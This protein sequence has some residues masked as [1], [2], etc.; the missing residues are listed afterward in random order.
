[1][2]TQRVILAGIGEERLD[3]FL[4]LNAG[5]G[6]RVVGVID[7]DGDGE[8]ARIAEILGVQVYESVAPDRLPRAD[9]LIYG[10]ER[11]RA[12]GA[13]LDLDPS[14][15]WHENHAWTVLA[16]EERP[17]AEDGAAGED[18]TEDTHAG[19]GSWAATAPSRRPTADARGGDPSLGASTLRDP[20][21]RVRQEASA[22]PDREDADTITIDEHV[23]VGHDGVTTEDDITVSPEAA[24]G[25]RPSREDEIP[26]GEYV[27]ELD[28]A[29]ADDPGRGPTSAPSTARPGPI[30]ADR[31]GPASA[32]PTGPRPPRTGGG[33]DLL[34]TVLGR[35]QEPGDLH[36]WVLEQ[37]LGLTGAVAG[38]VV[39]TDPAQPAVW[40]DRRAGSDPRM[41]T[42]LRPGGTDAARTEVALGQNGDRGA[43]HLVL[44]RAQRTPEFEELLDALAPAFAFVAERDDL[45]RR[46][47]TD[48]LARE[49][50][51]SLADDAE[52]RDALADA[53]HRMAELLGAAECVVL[54]LTDHARLTGVTSTGEAM[55]VPADS[56]VFGGGEGPTR[57][58]D[59]AGRW[60]LHVP[61]GSD[62]R[63]GVL[64][65]H[66]VDPRA[67]AV[68]A[69]THEASGLARLLADRIP[70]SAWGGV[71]AS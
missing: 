22:G 38:S 46:A 49:L 28:T 30:P 59:E 63:R 31:S 34:R 25:S 55:S 50:S 70:A 35:L 68:E 7:E 39:P 21:D 65:V 15:V 23:T 33:Y 41:P 8:S 52:V 47:R 56:P 60:H 54:L 11:Y 58:L 29:S 1:M 16:S 5:T 12:L 32:D 27:T 19:S 2:D 62:D 10:V 61:F 36:R 9:V 53:A 40:R 64:A 69:I 18:A 48:A 57:L 26:T 37:A 44:I 3:L 6:F 14:K 45:R 67:G 13:S 43:A 66:G 24:R 17:A 42:F 4:L 20:G 51:G 71:T